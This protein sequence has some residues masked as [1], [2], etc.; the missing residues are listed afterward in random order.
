M[1]ES[2]LLEINSLDMHLNSLGP[3]SSSSPSGIPE[4]PSGH[5]VADGFLTFAVYCND[6][7]HSF[8]CTDTRNQRIVYKEE[9]RI[10]Q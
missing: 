10:R 7:Q 8:V 3:V 6:R 4:S 1:Q 5:T 2:G 9:I